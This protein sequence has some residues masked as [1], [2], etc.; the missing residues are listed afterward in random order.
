MNIFNNLLIIHNRCTV[1]LIHC[2]CLDKFKNILI[3]ILIVCTNE[4]DG[5]IKDSFEISTPAEAARV[6][7]LNL[8]KGT[9]R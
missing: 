9:Y 7:L 6:R 1:L 8:I 2:S 3:D 5:Q 4:F